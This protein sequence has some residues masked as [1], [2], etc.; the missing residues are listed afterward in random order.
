MEFLSG[1]IDSPQQQQPEDQEQ[2]QEQ[3]EPAS[4]AG[5]PWQSSPAAAPTTGAV[6]GVA[7]GVASGTSAGGG[8]SGKDAAH[9]NF[10]SNRPLLACFFPC[11]SLLV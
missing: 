5:L 1:I 8:V 9:R 10:T 2:E 11:G 3:E 7:G 4:A 6:G